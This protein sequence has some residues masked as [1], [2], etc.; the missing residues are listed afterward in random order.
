MFTS[1]G[2][3][4]VSR[5]VYRR[6]VY[7]LICMFDSMHGKNPKLKPDQTSGILHIPGFKA[8][9]LLCLQ[10][11]NLLFFSPL[12]WLSASPPP[13]GECREGVGTIITIK[14]RRALLEP[15]SLV[16]KRVVCSE[17]IMVLMLAQI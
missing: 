10:P 2:K 3:E 11:V 8:G 7:V 9:A 5:E 17:E 15:I 6:P 4:T 13:V 14:R 16:W 1:H 12:C